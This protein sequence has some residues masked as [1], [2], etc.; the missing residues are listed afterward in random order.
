MSVL[1]HFANEWEGRKMNRK[2][3]GKRRGRKGRRGKE[4]DKEEEGEE[5]EGEEEAGGRKEDNK[6]DYRSEGIKKVIVE[7]EYRTEDEGK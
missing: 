5:G 2:K 4:K 6:K 7:Y 3:R 1:F